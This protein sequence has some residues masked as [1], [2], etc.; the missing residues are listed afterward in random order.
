[1]RSWGRGNGRWR[2]KRDEGGGGVRK[3][4]LGA[5]II[6]A[7]RGQTNWLGGR[8]NSSGGDGNS[9]SSQPEPAQTKACAVLVEE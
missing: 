3:K 5:D 1:M 9:M 2:W 7:V 6:S 8:P 4:K